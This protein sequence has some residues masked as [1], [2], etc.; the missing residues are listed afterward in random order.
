VGAGVHEQCAADGA[1]NALR[2]L[3]AREPP[4]GGGAG[5]ASEVRPGPGPDLRSALAVVPVDTREPAAE[6]HHHA[7][8]ATVAD[9]H[10]R[11]AAE[12]AGAP[13][14]RPPSDGWRR[15]RGSARD[16]RGAPS[17]STLPPP[18]RAPGPS[19]RRG[20]PGA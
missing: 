18:A 4:A 17:R 8:H 14:A 20:G 10:V 2:V 16:R 19:A 3:E 9:E 5:E 6:L 11:A 15:H 7:A 13:A 1:G 12:P